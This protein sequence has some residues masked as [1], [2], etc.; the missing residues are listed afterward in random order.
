V[1]ILVTVVLKNQLGQHVSCDTVVV[2][3]KKAQQAGLKRK[4]ISE[5]TEHLKKTGAEHPE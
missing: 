1:V 5:E 3:Q 4:A 2:K